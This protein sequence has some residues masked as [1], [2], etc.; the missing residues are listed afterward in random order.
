MACIATIEINVV[1]CD[2]LVTPCIVSG[3]EFLCAVLMYDGYN[4]ALVVGEDI[5]DAVGTVRDK[6][7]VSLNLRNLRETRQYM[8]FLPSRI[9]SPPFWGCWTQ[10][11]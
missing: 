7:T 5:E 9:Y 8:T 4:T 2:G 1:T 6:G 10:R 3:M 11:P